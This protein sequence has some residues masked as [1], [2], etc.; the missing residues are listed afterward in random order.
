MIVVVKRFRQ[1]ECR[2]RAVLHEVDS[3]QV[4][5]DNDVA[6]TL[7]VFDKFSHPLSMLD[8]ILDRKPFAERSRGHVVPSLE[9]RTALIL[10]LIPHASFDSNGHRK[11]L[12]PISECEI[13]F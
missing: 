3:T 6:T 11:I 1:L 10:L 4:V 13:E 2:E 7:C 8:D 5:T 12:S 9:I